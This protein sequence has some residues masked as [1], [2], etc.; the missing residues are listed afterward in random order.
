MQKHLLV[1]PVKCEDL[2]FSLFYIILNK[3]LCGFDFCS[4]KTSDWALGNYYVHFSLSDI[5]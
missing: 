3:C 4:E 2:S 5:L 1:Q